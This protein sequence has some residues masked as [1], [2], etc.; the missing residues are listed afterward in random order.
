MKRED[1]EEF[2]DFGSAS[3]LPA[4]SPPLAASADPKD[5]DEFGDFGTIAAPPSAVIPPVA[6]AV[7]PA[8]PSVQDDDEFNNFSSFTSTSMV[9]PPKQTSNTQPKSS[10]ISAALTASAAANV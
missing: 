8:A 10:K 9:Q 1:S 2:G 4:S 7:T 5:D 3:S 6:Q